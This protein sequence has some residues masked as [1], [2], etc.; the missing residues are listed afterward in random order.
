MKRRRFAKKLLAGVA[1]CA[2]VLSTLTVIP[3]QETKAAADTPRMIV[4]MTER[5]GEI[6]HGA[7]GFLYGISSEDVPTTDLITPL[8]PTVLAT[9]GMLGT[10]HPYGDAADVAETFFESGGKMVQMYTSNYYAIFGPRPDNTQ[11]AE[12]LKE[13]IVPAVVEW[14]E[15]FKEEHGTPDSPKDELGKIDIDKAIVYLPI[16]EGAPQVDP[17]T[18]VA[19]NH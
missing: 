6:L 3:P 10:E 19:D 12:D 16:N 4:D 7:S 2:A 17:E 5:Q 8:K 9:K 18:G 1:S 15:N 11:Y 13:T 14:K